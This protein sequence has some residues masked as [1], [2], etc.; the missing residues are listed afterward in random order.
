MLSTLLKWICSLL[1]LVSALLAQ[2]TPANVAQQ[3]SFAGLRTS[4]GKGH[5]LSVA[6]DATQSIYLL[7]DQGD[8]VRVMKLSPD[9]TK[10]LAEAILGQAGDVGSAM[11]L[12]PTGNVYITGTSSSGQLHATSGAAFSNPAAGTSGSFVA[13]FDA[14]LNPSWVS[15]T[16]GSRIS[17]SAVAANS[18]A[19]FVTGITYGSDLPVS[20][21]AIIQQP[22][23]GSVQNGFVEKFSADGTSLL[24]DSYVSG[25]AG[26]TTPTGIAVDANDDAWLVGSTTASGFP[27][28]AALVP[29]A[30]S[31]PSGFLMEFTPAADGIIFSTFV[32]G[33]GLASVAL[34]AASQT[35]VA[36]GNVAL[37]QFPLDTVASPLVPAAYQSVLRFALDGSA[38]LNGT[39]I[40]PGTRSTVTISSGGSAWIAG[41]FDPAF[42]PLLPQ[43]SIAAMG[44][45]FAV[46]L[47]AAGVI[48]QTVR[49]GG[50]PVEDQAF[51]GIPVSLSALAVQ[52][53][54]AL[55]A[56]G[57]VQPTAS[58]SLLGVERYELPLDNRGSA[59]LGSSVAD[60]EPAPA[61]CGGSLCSGS[62]AL[63]AIVQTATSAAGPALSLD[64]L[65]FGTLRNLGSADL[66]GLRVTSS[67]GSIATNCPPTLLAG[68][69][70]SLLLSG[71]GAG[72]LTVSSSNA[73]AISAPFPSYQAPAG[74]AVVYSPREADF[75]IVTSASGPVSR[76]FTLTNLGTA[77]E[78]V[79]SGPATSVLI[80]SPFFE[81]AERLYARELWC[82]QGVGAWFRLPRHDQPHGLF[83]FCERWGATYSLDLRRQ[84]GSTDGLYAGGIS[85][86]V[87]IGDRLWRR[88]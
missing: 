64:E 33:T 25:A 73:A 67:A 45:S 48:D 71:G 77:S 50:L 86:L 6:T 43:S 24:Y 53:D 1:L 55:L 69:E 3:L 19:V 13:R 81:R 72:V 68:A 4:G 5:F 58:S 14:D 37:G 32:P 79:A 51:A 10:L 75:G 36:S 63:L 15:F 26:D 62:A 28:L 65:P 39:V 8:G 11:T 12:D 54:G 60:A 82:R 78:T 61:S 7:Y 40:A 30:L 49:F 35:L 47:N 42:P 66:E 46:R 83:R 22:A 17:A 29:E 9:A 59:V 20:D 38:V 87:G 88:L 34:D 31:N 57:S 16:G 41:D 2:G 84:A 52:G 44:G 74:G 18:N 80:Q 56:A 27:T 70:C 85:R 23:Y 76:T 21:S